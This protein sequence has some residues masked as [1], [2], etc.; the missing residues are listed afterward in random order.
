ME[1]IIETRDLINERLDLQEQI[2]ENFNDKFKK[3]VSDYYDIDSSV[4][5]TEKGSYADFIVF[6]KDEY[7]KIEEIDDLEK[8]IGSEFYFGV[9]LIYEDYFKDYCKQLVLEIGDLPGSLPRYIY[10]N[11]DWQGVAEDLK[12]DYSEV[13]YK[14]NTYYYRA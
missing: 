1:L 3:E 8:A 4:E 10:D 11:I 14:E 9:S 6:W 13:Y 5:E 7:D 2:L 12:Q